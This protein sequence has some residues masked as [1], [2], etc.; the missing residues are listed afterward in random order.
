MVQTDDVPM[1][2]QYMD[3]A[4]HERTYRFFTGLA[5]WGSVTV[6]VILILLALFLV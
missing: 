6:A 1:D 5:K 3:Y 4:E 2:S